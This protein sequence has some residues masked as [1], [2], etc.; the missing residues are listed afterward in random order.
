MAEPIRDSAF[1]REQAA[2]C[3]RVAKILYD[4]DL[5]DELLHYADEFDEKAKQVADELTK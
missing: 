3:R 5:R 1:Y 2:R 4:Q